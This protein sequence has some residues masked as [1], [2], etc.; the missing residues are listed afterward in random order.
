MAGPTPLPGG[1]S[2]GQRAGIAEPR[3]QGRELARGEADAVDVERAGQAAEL[4]RRGEQPFRAG[5]RARV[6]PDRARAAAAARSVGLLL[7]AGKCAASIASPAAESEPRG[8]PGV[9]PKPAGVYQIA[10]AARP[11]KRSGRT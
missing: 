1:G 9:V 5:D 11:P 10:T 7:A 6:G 8:A 3:V 2:G 4:G